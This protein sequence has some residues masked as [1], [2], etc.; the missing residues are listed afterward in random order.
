MPADAAAVSVASH[1]SLS[2][3]LVARP[4]VVKWSIRH[5]EGRFSK[6]SYVSEVVSKM[7]K[8]EYMIL[9]DADMLFVGFPW[10]EFF[11]RAADA[12]SPITGTIRQATRESV[13]INALG[14]RRQWFQVFDASWWKSHRFASN[15]KIGERHPNAQTAIALTN[16]EWSFSLA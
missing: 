2:S 9:T 7:A 15:A 1:P 12:A 5:T 8:F 3:P 13:L 4:F 14:G 16:G 6:Y 11:E 10:A